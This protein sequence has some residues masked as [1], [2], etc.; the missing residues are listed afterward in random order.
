MGWRLAGYELEVGAGS[1][2]PGSLAEV[3]HWVE[4]ETG[5]LT[6]RARIRSIAIDG[7]EALRS[8]SGPFYAVDIR[9]PEE[10]RAG[11]IP[12]S[13]SIPAG[14]L[15]LQH[16][17]F[18][19]IRRAPVVV[20]SD[21]PVRPI[22]AAALCQDLGFA[23]VSVLAGGIRAWAAAGHALDLGEALPRVFRLEEARRHIASVDARE[24]DDL[25][26][27]DAG[28]RILDVRGSGDFGT[29]HIP[30]S[31]WLARGKVE[32]GIDAAAP[33][34]P[35]PGIA[36]CDN[37]VRSTLA[38]ATLRFLGYADARLESPGPAD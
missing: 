27:R 2:R 20:L 22:W 30:G 33:D 23:S 26:A 9:L 6:E 5:A 24:L 18:L 28:I 35:A 14:Q 11:H 34:R 4:Q 19:A 21:D 17:N 3:P 13:I 1:G 37:G 31:H 16:E 36:V 10:F 38:A 32:L 15:A 12:G 29:R 7:F 25:R 8:S